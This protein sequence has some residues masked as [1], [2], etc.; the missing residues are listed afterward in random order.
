MANSGSF[1]TTH[2]VSGSYDTY[3]RFSWSLSSQSIANNTSTITWNFKGKAA[4][5]YQWIALYGSGVTVDGE[6]HSGWT[7]NMYEGTTLYSGTKTISHAADGTKTLS[8]SGWIKQYSSGAANNTGSGSWTL[9]TI[10]RQ[11]NLSTVQSF[12]DTGNPTITY[13]NAAGNSVTSLQACIADTTGNTVYVAYRNVNK[14]GTLSYTFNLTAAERNT[15]LAACPSST[16]LNV[17]FYLKTVIGSNTFYS[18]KDAVMTV[19]NG[20]PTFTN[21]AFA[22]TNS[23]I[24]GITGNNQ[25]LVQG[26]STLAVTISSANKA[27]ANKSATM[28]NY[29]ASFS[30]KS[31]QAN[32][33]SSG[34]TLTFTDNAFSSGSQLLS[35]KATDTRSNST[36]VTKNVTVLA[37]ANPVINMTATRLNNFEDTTTLSFS[38]S[39]SPLTVSGTNKNAVDNVSYRYKSQSTTTWGSWTAL[40]V[41]TASNGTLTIPNV[42]LSLAN[43]QAWDFQVR[44]VDKLATTTKSIVVSVGQ[45]AFFIGADGRVAVGGTPTTTKRS[46]EVGHL[47]VKGTMYTTQQLQGSKGGAWYLGRDNAVARNTYTGTGSIYAPV[48]SAKSNSGDWS[49]GCLKNDTS[50]KLYFSFCSDTNYS[51]A[52]NTTSYRYIDTAGRST[53]YPLFPVG[54]IFMTTTQTTVADVQAVLAGTWER[55]GQGKVLVGVNPDDTDF[56]AA[57]KTGGAKTVTLTADQI[58]SHRHSTTAA[59]SKGKAQA[60]TSG[61]SGYAWNA[62]SGSVTG[63]TGGGQ[64]HQNM[65]PYITVYMYRRTA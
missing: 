32:Y 8:A 60:Q 25:I 52:N 24:T 26:K 62:D 58:P 33:S 22:D 12:D 20:K 10:A 51:T 30:G 18:S 23:T 61:S 57:N 49:I 48:V 5:S 44:A 36:T 42:T 9:P 59:G 41:T 13:T 64:A 21:F 19:V 4:N 1:D 16:T 31:V 27:V 29:V 55:F 47:E 56:N 45:P 63:Y 46:G 11:A 6:S 54:S 43:N 28:V 15:L 3:A 50:N 35:V 2:R 37:Y 7:G 17:K 53:I 40:T 38:G 14:T 34:N 39:I 65:P